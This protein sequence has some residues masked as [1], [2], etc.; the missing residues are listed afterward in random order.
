[1]SLKSSIIKTDSESGDHQMDAPS[2]IP[3]VRSTSPPGGSTLKSQPIPNVS[4][5]PNIY[6]SGDQDPNMLIDEEEW[7]DMPATSI[8]D[9]DV[10]SAQHQLFRANVVI[11]QLRTAL[12]ETKLSSMQDHLQSRLLRIEAEEAFRRYEVESSIQKREI[13][14]LRMDIIQ[15]HTGQSTLALDAEETRTSPK[16][17]VEKYK[18][19]LLKAKE[20]LQDTHKK[21]EERNLEIDRLKRQLQIP[22]N[23]ND[24][25]P[26]TQAHDRSDSNESRLGALGMLAS[27]FL[28]QQ[29]LG[30]PEFQA[31]GARNRSRTTSAPSSS[32]TK[33]P[34]HMPRS[35]PQNSLATDGED[36]DNEDLAGDT[37]PEDTDISQVSEMQPSFVSINN[38]KSNERSAKT[39][40]SAALKMADSEDSED[41]LPRTTVPNYIRSTTSV[42]TRGLPVS[43]SGSSV[44][45]KPARRTHIPSKISKSSNRYRSTSPSKSS[46]KSLSLTSN[47]AQS[48]NIR[49]R[50]TLKRKIESVPQDLAQRKLVGPSELN[51]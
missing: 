27:H 47:S 50:I 18:R 10:T 49:S 4:W 25:Q 5:I 48:L 16:E 7:E 41:D 42:S 32:Y 22:V 45:E 20:R 28:D 1:M 33:A 36:T 23:P 26:P 37:E 51:T 29:R 44:E 17:E 2:P 6:R 43:R 8:R 13:D 39:R 46:S 40:G 9:M 11:R 35:Q 30:D 14:R 21:L 34:V 19:R 38:R 12:Q 15:G 31:G 3:I 24:R